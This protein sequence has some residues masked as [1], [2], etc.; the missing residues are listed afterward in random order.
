MIDAHSG[1]VN[2]LREADVD[3]MVKA[4]F[5]K[6]YDCIFEMR[7]ENLV[8]SE[9][10]GESQVFDFKVKGDYYGYLVEF[11]TGD[12]ESKAAK[13]ARVA[14]AEETKTVEKDLVV[15]DPIRLDLAL[16][17]SVFQCE[18]FENPN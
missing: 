7:D 12:A 18:F 14:C 9:S 17:F 13:D 15:T 16:N 8:P 1:G 6:V 2:G 11:A 5:R 10:T 4:D 3:G